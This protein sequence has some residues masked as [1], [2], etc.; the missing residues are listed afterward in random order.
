MSPHF[1]GAG[2]G[3][4]HPLPRMRP[5]LYTSISTHA[6]TFATLKSSSTGMH[7]LDHGEWAT[8]TAC[9]STHITRIKC[10]ARY[11]HEWLRLRKQTSLYTQTLL[12]ATQTL[13]YRTWWSSRLRLIHSRITFMYTRITYAIAQTPTKSQVSTHS[14]GFQYHTLTIRPMAKRAVVRRFLGMYS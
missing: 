13:M 4:S 1:R 14:C 6:H 8:S 10:Q 7:A 2:Q 5:C 12:Y 11:I 3:H 9:A